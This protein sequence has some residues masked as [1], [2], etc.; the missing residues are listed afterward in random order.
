MK[1]DTEHKKSTSILEEKIKRY[2]E[3]KSQSVER[4]QTQKRAYESV[5][6]ALRKDVP[7]NKAKQKKRNTSNY[8]AGIKTA[9]V[10][11][12]FEIKT[13]TQAAVTHRDCRDREEVVSSF[14]EDSKKV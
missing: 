2:A 5:I 4:A 11:H 6:E 14:R 7:N 13:K 12:Q 9:R 10:R 8:G 1:K 3:E